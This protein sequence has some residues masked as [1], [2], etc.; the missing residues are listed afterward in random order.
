MDWCRWWP[1]VY[2]LL[3]VLLLLSVSL[4]SSM[5]KTS[6]MSSG[7][8][9]T[10]SSLRNID[11]ILDCPSLLCQM[12]VLGAGKK[13]CAHLHAPGTRYDLS[14]LLKQSISWITKCCIA[15]TQLAPFMPRIFYLKNAITTLQNRIKLRCYVIFLVPVS[16]CI[17][18]LC[19]VMYT[20]LNTM[21]HILASYF[22]W[23]VPLLAFRS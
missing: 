20:V 10:A 12:V 15:A 19:S 22:C 1:A 2:A 3:L 14:S 17:N 8:A 16:S 11:A 6:N 13:P 4:S 5:L 21:A 23:L 7:Q 9:A 18:F